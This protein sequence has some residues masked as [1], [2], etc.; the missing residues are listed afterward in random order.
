MESFNV[1]YKRVLNDSKVLTNEPTLPRKGRPPKHLDD[2]T[3][4]FN[5]GTPK[6]YFQDWCE[7]L[8]ILIAELN[9]RFLCKNLI[10][11]QEMENI[12]ICACKNV[13]KKPSI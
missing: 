10:L 2:G 5:P 7:A 9:C 6:D 8:N 3:E 4:C 13:V 11:L 1:L 12:F